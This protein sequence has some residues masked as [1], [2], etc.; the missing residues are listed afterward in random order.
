MQ[1]GKEAAARR[2]QEL[3]D[4]LRDAGKDSREQLD[5]RAKP[6]FSSRVASAYMFGESRTTAISVWPPRVADDDEAR[7]GLVRVPGLDAVRARDTRV[8]IRLL[9]T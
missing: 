7:A 2:E 3:A 5:P 8:S 1:A 6:K 9:L 4:E